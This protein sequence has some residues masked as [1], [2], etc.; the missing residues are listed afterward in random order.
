MPNLFHFLQN[1]IVPLYQF[2]TYPL[3]LIK[4]YI[5]RP[6]IPIFL[7]SNSIEPYSINCSQMN[8]NIDLGWNSL[9]K[10]LWPFFPPH[11]YPCIFSMQCLS[12]FLHS[13]IYSLIH[14]LIE[15]LL[16]AKH[17]HA[18]ANI[19]KNG[20]WSLRSSKSFLGT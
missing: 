12:S 2:N 8:P 11:L 4:K 5:F 16:Y 6:K 13:F 7:N 10:M 20:A 17:C 3:N 15:F 14:S 19:K 18:E 1:F 9:S